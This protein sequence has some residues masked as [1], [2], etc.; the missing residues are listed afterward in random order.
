MGAQAVS[1][2]TRFIACTEF[3]VNE[4]W[5]KMVVNAAA[6][7]AVQSE[8]LNP[9]MPPYNTAE[10]WHGKRAGAAKCLSG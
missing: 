3:S 5:K 8:A 7:D 2:G 9:M 4:E 6:E 10:P 1:M